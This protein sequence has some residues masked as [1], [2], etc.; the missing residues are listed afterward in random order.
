MGGLT[1]RAGAD[2]A[3]RRDPAQWARYYIVQRGDRN[4]AGG[5]GQGGGPRP[6]VQSGIL[7]LAA[8][9]SC[10]SE[11]KAPATSKGCL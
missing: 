4:S 7:P 5:F 3:R 1:G 2:L 6:Q 11:G 10:T 9:R 8:A